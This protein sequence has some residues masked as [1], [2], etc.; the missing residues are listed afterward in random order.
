MGNMYEDQLMHY[1]V[2]GMHW[3]IRRYQ[4]YPAAYDGDGK[5]IGDK[6]LKKKV[7]ADEKRVND[8]VKEASVL[9]EAMIQGQK[10][11]AK[12][13]NKMVKRLEKDPTLQKRSS[14]RLELD[15][16]AKVLAYDEIKAA[17]ERAEKAARDMV[18]EFKKQYGE[19]NVKDIVYAT[20]KDGTKFVADQVISGKEIAGAILLTAASIPAAMFGSPV[21]WAVAPTT[22]GKKGKQLLNITTQAAKQR[23]KDNIKQNPGFTQGQ[24]S[25]I[26]LANT[27]SGAKALA[28]AIEQQQQKT[29]YGK[30]ATYHK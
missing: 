9:G 18:D 16:T 2:M 3:G 19:Q 5:Y 12:A 27:P 23:L 11:V 7:K 20:A 6:A 26:N 15:A 24:V 14:Q 25:L 4:P 17:Y 28:L 29:S 22:S 1:G 8:L 13:A 30:P 10:K 21:I